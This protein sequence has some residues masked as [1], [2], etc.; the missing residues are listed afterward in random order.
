MR[1]QTLEQLRLLPLSVAQGG[2]DLICVWLIARLTGSLVN[3]NLSGRLPEVNVVG[4]APF[5][6]TLWLIGALAA[7][8]GGLSPGGQLCGAQRQGAGEHQPPGR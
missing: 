1:S 8:A 7:S 5:M 2:F 4:V 3:G 6:Q